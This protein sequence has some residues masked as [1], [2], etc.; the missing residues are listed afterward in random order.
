MLDRN[1][2]I[3]QC[4][5]YPKCF[6][7]N[8]KNH[9]MRTISYLIENTNPMMM[10]AMWNCDQTKKPLLHRSEYDMFLLELESIMNWEVP[11][12]FT[13]EWLLVS[14]RQS[15]ENWQNSIPNRNDVAAAILCLSILMFVVTFKLEWTFFL[16]KS[17]RSSSV[18]LEARKSRGKCHFIEY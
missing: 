4:Q 15:I 13:G 18:F 2:R 12:A 5:R 6:R 17:F 7:N 1:P 14:I 10:S 16:G 11:E 8:G 3:E 9:L